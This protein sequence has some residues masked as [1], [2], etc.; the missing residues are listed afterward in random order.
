MNPENLM[1]AIIYGLLQQ[2]ESDVDELLAAKEVL[3]MI[4]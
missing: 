1:I 3:L 2:A 4:E